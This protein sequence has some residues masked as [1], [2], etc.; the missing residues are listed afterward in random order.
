MYKGVEVTTTSTMVFT[1]ID[2]G[3]K[4]K[5]INSRDITSITP[6]PNP[7][8]LLPVGTKVRVFEEWDTYMSKEEFEVQS[9]Y[10]GNYV[11]K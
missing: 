4:E 5:E 8:R 2:K 9:I 11:L 1:S 7:P 10:I 3:W 6:I